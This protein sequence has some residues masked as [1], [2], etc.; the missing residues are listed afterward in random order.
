MALLTRL[1]ASAAAA[2]SPAAPV[3]CLGVEPFWATVVLLVERPEDSRELEVL[4]LA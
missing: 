3:L 2:T 1:L 4:P